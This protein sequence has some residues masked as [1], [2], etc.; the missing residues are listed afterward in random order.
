LEVPAHGKRRALWRQHLGQEVALGDQGLDEVAALYNLGL[1]GIQKACRTAREIAAFEGARLE[2][3][4][5]GQAVRML[6]EGEL[7][8]V[9]TH[10]K[11]TQTWDDLVLP[12]ELGVSIQAILE[13]IRYREDVLGDWGFANKLGKGW[14]LT[15]LLSGEPGTG[16]SMLAALIAAELG[17]DL[18]VIDLYPGATGAVPRDRLFYD[19]SFFGHRSCAGTTDVVP[20]AAALSGCRNPGRALATHDSQRDA[21]RE[22]HRFRRAWAQV[23]AFRWV[24]SC[25]V[26]PTGRE[27][28]GLR[29]DKTRSRSRPRRSIAIAGSLRPVDEWIEPPGRRCTAAARI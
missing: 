28:R 3:K 20:C 10:V 26:Q 6:F 21:A 22:R 12:E 2:R 1:S 7:A 29:W 14:G 4:H 16:K 17:L 18:Y 23:R 11:V 25:C 9:A 5:I 13:R 15:V 24:Y 19:Q 27:A 8:T